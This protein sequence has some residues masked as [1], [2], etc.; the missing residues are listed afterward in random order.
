MTS[1]QNGVGPMAY[2]PTSLDFIN[3][4][5]PVEPHAVPE[6]HPLNHTQRLEKASH[7]EFLRLLIDQNGSS[8]AERPAKRRKSGE[9]KLLDLPRLPAVRSGAKR[10][11]IPPTLSGL[12]QPPPDAGLLPSIS[13]EQPINLPSRTSP[14]EAQTGHDSRPETSD[15]SPRVN[16]SEDAAWQHNE[17]PVKQKRKKWTDDETNVLLKGVARFGIGNWTQIL[18]SPDFHFEDRTAIDLKD[19]FRVCCPD[20]YKTSRNSKRGM[21]SANQDSPAE[22]VTAEPKVRRPNRS[23]RK[24][25]SELLK[26]GIKGPF[27]RSKR[28]RRTDYTAAE[29]EALL[30]G[31]RKHD[32]SWAAIRQDS[33][34]KLAHR[35]ATDLRDRFRTKYPEQYEKAG[36]APRREPESKKAS[37]ATKDIKIDETLKNP[38][39]AKATSAVEDGGKPSTKTGQLEK[40]NKLPAVNVPAQKQ[41]VASLLYLDPDVFWGAPF[42][43]DETEPER[44]TLD[45]RILDWPSETARPTATENSR[46]DIDPLITFNYQRHF[47]GLPNTGTLVNKSSSAV[48]VLPSLAH[49][50]AASDDLGGHLELPSLMGTFGT[51]DSDGRTGPTLPSLEELWK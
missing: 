47:I 41:P 6:K 5:N 22:N 33:S 44:L 15:P 19:R 30:L 18:N 2:R 13:V 48:D 42:D 10:L 25:S 35:R 49:V 16:P 9:A 14:L 37:Q 7:P 4:P 46:Y 45:R 17:V 39:N 27:E 28:R 31:F 21:T 11:R 36:L 29:D 8:N 12:H 20:E 23:D 24:S 40:E 32:N 34:L 38:A 26:I 51:L 50:T 1:S 43:V 3:R